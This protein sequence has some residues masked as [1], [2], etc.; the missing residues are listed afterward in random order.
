[1]REE[2]YSSCQFKEVSDTCLSTVRSNLRIKC[3]CR[4]TAVG[5]LNAHFIINID[6]HD[7]YEISFAMGLGTHLSWYS[8]NLAT[9]KTR[10]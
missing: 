6:K 7:D 3:N 9:V 10:V 2:P 5:D 8:T 4:I 1:M